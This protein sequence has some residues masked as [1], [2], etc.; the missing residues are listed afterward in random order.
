MVLADIRSSKVEAYRDES[1]WAASR[2]LVQEAGRSRVLPEDAIEC[3]DDGVVF[4]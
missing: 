4:P 2:G 3:D 1:C